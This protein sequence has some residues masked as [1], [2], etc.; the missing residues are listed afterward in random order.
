MDPL[1]ELM[2]AIESIMKDVET[3][4]SQSYMTGIDMDT[5]QSQT[6][7]KVQEELEKRET[8]ISEVND[9]L[10]D[11]M[12]SLASNPDHSPASMEQVTRIFNF[13]AQYDEDVV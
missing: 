3:V 12:E 11:R 7:K 4:R 2:R 6:R 9:Q 10:M 1:F 5:F 8:S 13:L